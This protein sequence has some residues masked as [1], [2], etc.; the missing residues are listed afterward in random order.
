M[1]KPTLKQR[2]SYWFDNM[3]AK[4]TPAMIGMLFIV[5]IIIILLISTVVALFGFA[6]NQE[7]F[8]LLLWMG[9][10]RTLDSGT[11][12]GDEGSPL[13]LLMMLLVTVG[14]IFIFSALIGVLSAGLEER[15]ETLR[16][17]R[18]K[19]LESGHT[20]I[21]GWS[22]QIFT[23]IS[24]LIIANE[25]QSKG[26]I[27]VLADRDKVEME[28]QIRERVGDFGNTQVIVRSGNPIDL[29]DLELGNPHSAGSI[30]VLPPENDNPDSDV[31]KTILAITNNP[32]RHEESYHIVTQIQYRK[33][34]DVVKMIGVKD[35]VFPILTRDLI[36]RVVAQTSR[37]TGLSVVY[38]ELMNFGGDEIYFKEET[39]L[40]GKPFGEAL[41][42]YEDSTVMGLRRADGS[43]LLNPAM[44]TRL[45]SGDHLFAL[46]EDDDTIQLSGL[47]DVPVADNLIST[48]GK[49]HKRG[50]ERTL[51]IGW[52]HSAEIIVK[53]LD[54]YVAKG[55]K[56][57]VLAA[58]ARAKKGIKACERTLKNQK[59]TY[60]PGDTT[61]RDLLDSLNIMEYDHVI[62]LAV[63]DLEPQ[64][65]DARTLVT[66]LHLRDIVSHD[67]T[68]FSIVS[69]MLD[70][71][72]RELAEVT[73]VDDFIVSDHL[74]SLM[75][76]QLSENESLHD[77][78][79]DIFS[80]EGAEI[81]LNPVGNY[82]E[83]G[84]PVAF[85]TVVEAARRRGETA[86]G[87]RISAESNTAEKNYGVY[88]NPI[89]SNQITF[90][91]A[92]KIIVIAED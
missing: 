54:H 35:K 17:G 65:S 37:Q 7:G 25:N 10:M 89:K 24:E 3:M 38:T 44:D 31:I 57:T 26:H 30:I 73:K 88:T 20:L 71:R 28:E 70:L 52:N 84:Q 11:V 55:S 75:L 78:F 51:L 43:I 86:L 42:A 19:V 12:A 61:D 13:F 33:N 63:A 5:S 68:P 18:S 14:G 76:A 49:A 72:N 66:L 41:L 34:L 59:L 46:S 90:E 32:E 23:I 92:D 50:P 62:V 58:D 29:N 15:L 67:E 74:I 8:V 91:A 9:L 2:F 48:S 27:V 45:E 85:Y 56:V 47:Q 77:V 79:Q 83:A 36:A 64:A 80:P 69:E 60:V 1:K 53:E 82:V 40:V 22:T 87:Y 21:L 39:S 16:K 6:P 4:G 81:Y